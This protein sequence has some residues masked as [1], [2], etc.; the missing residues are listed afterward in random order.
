[1]P[2]EAPTALLKFTTERCITFL[3]KKSKCTDISIDFRCGETKETP[4]RI[5]RGRRRQRRNRSGYRS[6][7]EEKSKLA[8]KTDAR[9]STET[10]PGTTT[11]IIM[12]Y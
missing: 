11:N 6:G 9:I 10:I 12:E 3:E 5:R 7:G 4:K 2:L 8:I 1:L